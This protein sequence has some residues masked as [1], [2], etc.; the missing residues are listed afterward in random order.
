MWDFIV[1]SIIAY[2]YYVRASSLKEVKKDLIIQLDVVSIVFDIH[3]KI[4]SK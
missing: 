1:Y 2:Y 4:T 3:E